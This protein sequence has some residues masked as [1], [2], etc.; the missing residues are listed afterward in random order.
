MYYLLYDH[1]LK[2]NILTLYL[3]LLLF[4]ILQYMGVWYEYAAYP[5]A[6]EIG[7]KCIYAN[8]SLIDNSTVSVVNAAINRL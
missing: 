5:F 2:R 8:Y 1:L 4:R 6:F 3:L 7:K